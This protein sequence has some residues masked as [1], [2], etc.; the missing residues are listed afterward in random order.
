MV[1]HSSEKLRSFNISCLLQLGNILKCA[2]CNTCHKSLL[3]ILLFKY[4]H[5]CFKLQKPAY[6]Q[7]ERQK[8]LRMA[9]PGSDKTTRHPSYLKMVEEAVGE[10]DVIKGLT[11]QGI[12]QY[13]QVKYPSA[14]ESV[15]FNHFVRTAVLRGLDRNLICRQARIG[16]QPQ[17]T[18]VQ[19]RFK[20]CTP[21]F[22]LFLRLTL[23][24]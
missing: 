17:V 8:F 1:D 23:P 24:Q 21:S 9:L 6:F 13:I 12:K 20:V 22:N 2:D 15:A 16:Q 4:I 19:G 7:T 14:A 11:I 5:I 3:L 18:G 10:R